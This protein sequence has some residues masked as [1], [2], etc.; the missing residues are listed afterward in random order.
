M[1]HEILFGALSFI[2]DDSAW[3]RDA[4]LDVEALPIEATTSVRAGVLL[5]L[6][7][8]APVSIFA[9][10]TRRNKRSR[11]SRLLR[12]VRHAQAR[13]NASSQ[14]AVLESVVVAP[15]SQRLDSVPTEL[16]SEYLGRGPAAEVLM[17]NSLESPRQTSR[18]EH[19]VGESSGARR[20][21]H[22]S[23]S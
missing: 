6:Q 17:A 14:V 22:R 11:G 21:P 3:L 13:Q 20:Q 10:V 16:P 2:V 8:P 19:E 23:A 15:P 12:W 5:L 9:P 18:N 7:Q 1:G 4:P